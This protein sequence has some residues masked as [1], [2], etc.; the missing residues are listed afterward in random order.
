M[1]TNPLNNEQDNINQSVPQTTQ[2]EHHNSPANQ[3]EGSDNACVD[4]I[5][6]NKHGE[7][8]S[9]PQQ[10][11]LANKS[12][13]VLY[14][15]MM[16]YHGQALRDVKSCIEGINKLHSSE[17]VMNFIVLVDAVEHYLDFHK[18]A[19]AF[20]KAAEALI[21]Y[22]SPKLSQ[23][24]LTRKVTENRVV[25]FGQRSKNV[26][27]WLERVEYE[28]SKL[29]THT[30][31]Q[32]I[33]DSDE[34]G[35]VFIP[36]SEIQRETE[37]GGEV[38]I[39]EAQVIPCGADSKPRVTNNAPQAVA[40]MGGRAPKVAEQELP[41]LLPNPYAREARILKHQQDNEIDFRVP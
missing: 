27:E 15:K 38:E 3:A 23:V 35:E 1:N 9:K 11:Q 34:R 30:I 2:P 41:P 21:N 16:L 19:L 6:E 13:D 22:Q 32:N 12:I 31:I 18:N 36:N 17:D 24:D 7:P 37:I 4:S 25:E 39:E 40:T 29:P 20:V 14:K 28:Q 5:S 26:E 33:F 10:T 8:K